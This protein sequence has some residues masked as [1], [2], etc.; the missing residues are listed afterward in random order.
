M[1]DHFRLKGAESV[2]DALMQSQKHLWVYFSSYSASFSSFKE[3]LLGT[4]RAARS[5]GCVG[6]IQ[7][8][9]L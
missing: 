6:P 7:K 9:G 8:H 1:Q 4:V 2:C 3:N 5:G